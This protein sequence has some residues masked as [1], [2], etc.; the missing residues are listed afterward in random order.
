[1]L[2]LISPA[3][4]LDFEPL[5]KSVGKTSVPDFLDQSAALIEI[6]RQFSP[7][8][9]A[10]LMGLSDKLA[11][12]NFERFQS[13]QQ[14]MTVPDAKPS[15]FAFMGD[16]Y[17]G[18]DAQTLTD[19]NC[20]YLNESL[21]ILSGLYGLLRPLDLM[22]PYRLE[23]GTKLKN[24]AG[25]DLYDFWGDQLATAINAL[26]A[27]EIV[28]LASNEYFKSVQ[29]KRLKARVITPVFEDWSAGKYKIVSFYAKRA[30]GLMVRWA[31]ERQ[32]TKPEQLKDFDREGYGF[33]PE[34]SDEDRWIF[35]R[36]RV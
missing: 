28:N 36:K 13:W 34:S 17:E 9:I 25:K 1:M 31:A 12:L 15:L 14:Q 16:V 2:M 33:I 35:R 26:D 18:I 4:T 27:G 21:R 8:Q 20:L 32:V 24:S 22:R 23:M 7:Q 29:A 3:K 11:Y 10:E 6:L 30:R 19:E 5:K